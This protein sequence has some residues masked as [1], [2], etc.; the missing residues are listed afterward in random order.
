VVKSIADSSAASPGPGLNPPAQAGGSES[1]PREPARDSHGSNPR[2]RVNPR[3]SKPETGTGYYERGGQT[4]RKKGRKQRPLLEVQARR[5]R[6]TA[7]DR[8]IRWLAKAGYT[9]ENRVDW[10]ADDAPVK[11]DAFLALESDLEAAKIFSALISFIKERD[12]FAVD[13]QN[14]SDVGIWR[15]WWKDHKDDEDGPG[16]GEGSPPPRGYGAFATGACTAYSR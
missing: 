13:Q 11:T 14:C 6:K 12:S 10:E 7:S 3:A 1:A 2:P 9:P 5:W 4:F 16:T 15:K 8:V